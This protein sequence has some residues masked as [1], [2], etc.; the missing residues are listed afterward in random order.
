MDYSSTASFAHALFSA[1]SKALL[2]P[3]KYK[4]LTR[5]K[6]ARISWITDKKGASFRLV[7]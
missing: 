7:S 2:M 4:A 6:T 5:Q 1:F 3:A